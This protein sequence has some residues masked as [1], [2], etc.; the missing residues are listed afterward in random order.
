MQTEINAYT[1]EVLKHGRYSN[2]TKEYTPLTTTNKQ[3]NDV[4]GLNSNYCSRLQK[5]E[6]NQKVIGH[7]YPTAAVKIKAKPKPSSYCTPLSRQGYETLDLRRRSAS[8]GSAPIIFTCS[9]TFRH[10]VGRCRTLLSTHGRRRHLDRP[11]AHMES[12]T[13]RFV[14][15]IHYRK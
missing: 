10:T 11:C 7:L 13:A 15:T 4:V 6:N 2:L 12:L 8:L 9:V 3:T 1:G 14:D 5:I